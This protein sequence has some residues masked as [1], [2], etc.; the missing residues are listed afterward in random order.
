MK[1]VQALTMAALMALGSFCL[2]FAARAAETATPEQAAP[3]ALAQPAAPEIPGTA[4]TARA[5]VTPEFEI[6]TAEQARTYAAPAYTPVTA[7]DTKVTG[8]ANANTSLAMTLIARYNAGAMSKDGGSMEIVAYN[9]AKTCAYAVSGLKGKLVVLPLSGMAEGSTVQELTGTELDLAAMVNSAS[10]TYGDLTSVAVSPDGGK[11]AVAVQQADTAAAGCVAVFAVNDDGSLAAV[12]TLY[13]T[14]VQPDNVVFADD[15][16]ILTA[17][18]GEP[19]D[20]YGAG[21]TDPAGTVS[22]IDLADG[23]SVQAG[24]D[25]FAA[26]ELLD[27]NILLGK[28]DGVTQSP[29][30]DL[31]PEYI[32][33]AGGVAYVSLQEANAIGVLN[34]AD[35]KFTAV[36]SCGFEDFSQVPV[37]LN[38]DGGYKAETYEN[39]AGARMP[40]GISSVV[41]GGQTYL[42]TANEGDAREWGGY[43]NETKVKGIAKKAIRALDAARCDGLPAGKTVLFGGRSFTM[44]RM[45]ATGMTPVYDSADGFESLTAQYLPDRFNVSNDDLDVDSRSQK[46]GPEPESVTTGTVGGRTYAFIALERVGGVMAYDITDPANVS[47]VNYINSRS[48]GDV[49]ESDVS[50]EGLCLAAVNGQNYLL[51]ACEVSGTL[52]AYRLDARVVAQTD[53]QIL[54]TND[55]HTAYERSADGSRL[56]YAAVAGRKNALEAQGYQVTLVDG[57]DAIQGE[58]AGTLSQGAYLVDMMNTTGYDLAAIGNHEFDYGMAR[59]LD[60]S[61]NEANYPYISCNFIDLRTNKTVFDPYRIIDYGGKKVAYVGISTPETFTKSTPTYFQD[62]NGKYIY[63]FCEGDNGKELYTAVQNAIDAAKADGADTVIA[64]GHVG[65]DK[66]SEPWTSYDI[67]ANTTGLTA[68]LDAHSHSTIAGEDRTDKSGA[69]VRLMSTGTKLAAVGQLTLHADGSVDTRLLTNADLPAAQDDPAVAAA[70]QA[71]TGQFSALLGKVVATTN[72]DL[73]VQ[74]PATGKRLI[75][76]QETNMG[77]LCADAYRA[78]LG[79]DVAIVNGGG[80]RDNIAAGEITY[81]DIIAVHPF[82][83]AACLVE[84]TGQELLDVL[85]M[86]SRAASAQNSELGGFL[87]VSGITYEIDTTIPTSVEVDDKGM[88]VGVN[89]A[90][91]VKNVMVGGVPI[92]PAKTYT[93]ASHNYLLKSGGDG[94]NMFMDNKILQNEVLLDNEVLINYITGTLKGVISGDAYADAYG[95]KRIKVITAYQAPTATADGYQEYLR[96]AETVR[97]VLKATGAQPSAKPSA[98]PSANPTVQPSE[99]PTVQPTQQPTVA[100]GVV[101]TPSAQPTL[102]PAD[103]HGD[104]GP[105]KANGT[106]GQQD[107]A[108][109]AKPAATAS[110][111]PQTGDVT[112]IGWFV[113]LLAGS[114]FVLL[115]LLL[116]YRKDRRR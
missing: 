98:Q 53:I 35:K 105:A 13:P 25:G 83:N 97:E 106:W 75:R 26:Q 3:A 110:R 18:E 49:V 107:A 85:E 63:S 115:L 88:F 37:D 31:E 61:A 14:G 67:I 74:D 2:P 62:A 100:P 116:R 45:E 39:L 23:A 57:G 24:F 102:A 44:Y 33:V 59:F 10:F 96:G 43:T 64:V 111:V 32:T 11:V 52:A 12:P 78:M 38:E 112:P 36:Y 82:G 90:R 54:Y 42:L 68:F 72:V 19:R 70:A 91:R 103:A 5:T 104:I 34:L 71:I 51:A 108:A 84:A 86:A 81:G 94:L 6:G 60:L 65:I 50:P 4:E 9:A 15:N 99:K 21:T 8:F 113:L 28:V 79:A 17:D 7:L 27:Q 55:V 87:Q 46:K 30:L 114:G 101:G 77:D 109:T 66:V 41:I 89:G 95:A 76:S 80:I 73:T 48:Y 1:R 22:I 40:D 20:G 58:A 93:L 92:D 16:T 29:A 56:G 69:T 47:F